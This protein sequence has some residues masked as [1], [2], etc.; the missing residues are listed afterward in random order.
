MVFE[1]KARALP[2]LPSS[3]HDWLSLDGR[4]TPSFTFA[5]NLESCNSY[6]LFLHFVIFFSVLLYLCKF[7]ERYL[8][9]AHFPFLIFVSGPSNILWICLFFFFV[10]IFCNIWSIKQYKPF[11]F[12]TLN[13][14]S[15]PSLPLESNKC[16]LEIKSQKINRDFKHMSHVNSDYINNFFFFCMKWAT[17]FYSLWIKTC[18]T[19]SLYLRVAF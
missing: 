12:H 9:F 7:T 6:N 15:C 8:Q 14:I 4:S 11:H 3:Q 13:Y 17:C 1:Y 2:S 10:N 18:L 16:A 5:L 19:C